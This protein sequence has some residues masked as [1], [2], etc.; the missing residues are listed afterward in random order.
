MSKLETA[1]KLFFEA[2]YDYFLNA[3]TFDEITTVDIVYYIVVVV[4][5]L[6]TLFLISKGTYFI[7]MEY[8]FHYPTKKGQLS[9]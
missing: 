3:F 5:M 2:I 4:Y 6:W 1:V 8:K 9:W 7:G